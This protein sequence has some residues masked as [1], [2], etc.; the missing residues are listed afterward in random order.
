[1]EDNNHDALDDW[2][3]IIAAAQIVMNA[4]Y[5]MLAEDG[6][7]EE[8]MDEQSNMAKRVV[9]HRTLPRIQ[10]QNLEHNRY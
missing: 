7:L 1:M 3:Y 9:D 2:D 10:R 8:E 5:V 4:N 6:V